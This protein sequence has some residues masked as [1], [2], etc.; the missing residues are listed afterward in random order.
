MFYTIVA[1]VCMAILLGNIAHIVYKMC[2]FNRAERINFI[3]NYKKGKV[4]IVYLVIMPLYFLAFYYVNKDI[5]GAFKSAMSGAVEL[6]ALQLA[7]SEMTA[8]L[9]NANAVYQ[10]ALYSCYVMAYLNYALFAASICHEN[11]WSWFTTLKFHLSAQTKCVILGNN[12]GSQMLYETCNEQQKMLVDV[13]TK[14][15]KTALY[16]KNVHCLS[17]LRW[18]MAMDWIL[19]ESKRLSKIHARKKDGLFNA[20][21]KLIVIVNTDD[22]DLNLKLCDGLLTRLEKSKDSV[23]GSLQINVYGSAEHADVYGEYETKGKGCMEYIDKYVLSAVELIDEYPMTQFLDER[24]IDYQT[25]LIK[26][27]VELN[28]VFVGFGKRN[29]Q[30]F[31]TMVANDQFLCEGENGPAVKQVNYHFFDRKSAENHKNL[32]HTYYRFRHIF[33]DDKEKTDFNAYLPMPELPAKEFYHCLDIHSISFYDEIKNIITK[34]KTSMTH[35][36]V[37]FGTDLEN[38]DLAHKLLMKFNEWGVKDAHIFVKIKGTGMGKAIEHLL[39][40]ENCHIFGNKKKC[41]YNYLSVIN[42][43]FENMALQRNYIYDV[44]YDLSSN[45]NVVVDEKYLHDKRLESRVRWFAERSYIER[46]SN[47]F[48]CLSLRQ[49]LQ[50][51]G[52][53]YRP[54]T[55]DGK[56]LSYDEYIQIYAGDDKPVLSAYHAEINKSVVEYTLQFNPSR[57]TNMAIQEHYRWNA[58]MITK[59]FIPATKEAILTEV[60]AKGKH[61]NGKSYL[62]RR[63]GNLTTMQGLIEFRKMTAERDGVSEE[64]KDVI[65]YDYQLL[66][67]AYWLLK[68]NGYKIVKK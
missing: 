44:E 67:D 59:G 58:Y 29:R 36:I 32:N 15:D 9:C 10:V 45:P 61:T 50:L 23:S 56:A 33:L 22:E 39:G 51:M 53:D 4:A 2:V 3:R 43:K 25:S 65:K 38:A 60:N 18:D 11:I 63:H 37:S 16:I 31:L 55:A 26:K 17:F 30:A 19:K 7:S 34:S 35:L 46:E 13:L 52:L 8:P 27:D 12:K 68:R 41:D 40:A 48:A 54:V 47:T 57:R 6:I 62:L 14:E 64:S 24:H 49:K 66:D 28:V 20:R 21:N 5:I 1:I 42:E